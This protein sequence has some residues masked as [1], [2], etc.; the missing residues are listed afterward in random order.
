[1]TNSIASSLMTPRE[2]KI[3]KNNWHNCK[4]SRNRKQRRGGDY[5]DIHD[6]AMW[7]IVTNFWE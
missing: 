3:D 7:V 2:K 6:K 5:T 1:M 4:N